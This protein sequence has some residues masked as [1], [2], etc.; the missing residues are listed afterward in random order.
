MSERRHCSQIKEHELELVGSRCKSS[1]HVFPL[2]PCTGNAMVGLKAL[3][4]P[5]H[6]WGGTK[7]RPYCSL[8]LPPSHSQSCSFSFY[9]MTHPSTSVTL[10]VSGSNSTA[11]KGKVSKYP[12][13]LCRWCKKI[14]KCPVYLNIINQACC[15]AS[16][17]TLNL[18]WSLHHHAR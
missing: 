2:Q 18:S 7:E 4:P 10:N 17:F 11:K 12:A 16:H 14:N 13:T 8:S 3:D 1:A 6:R 9:K 15:S 5:P